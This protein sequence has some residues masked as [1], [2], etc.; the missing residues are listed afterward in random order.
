VPR[1]NAAAS[2]L[3][4]D[5]IHDL[6]RDLLVKVDV[7]TLRDKLDALKDNVAAPQNWALVLYSALA[8]GVFGTM[9][10]GFGWL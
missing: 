5:A 2:N 8:A 10:R 1:R 6:S 3:F 7:R 4:F 9:A